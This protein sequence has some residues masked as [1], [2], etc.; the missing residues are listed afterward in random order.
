MTNRRSKLSA[1]AL[2]GWELFWACR[3]AALAHQLAALQAEPAF[4]YMGMAEVA[5]LLEQR[6]SDAQAIL[7]ITP[8]VALLCVMVAL[9]AAGGISPDQKT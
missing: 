4:P 5:H 7:M 2:A 3:W 8:V 6:I 9:A 1:V